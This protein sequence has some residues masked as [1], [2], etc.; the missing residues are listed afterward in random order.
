MS[1]KLLTKAI[2]LHIECCEYSYY[3]G[4]NEFTADENNQSILFLYDMLNHSGEAATIQWLIDNE[5][6]DEER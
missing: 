3:F 1:Y 5:Y 4:I 6:L 2:A